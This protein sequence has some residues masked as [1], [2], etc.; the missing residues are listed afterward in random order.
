MIGAGRQARTQVEAVCAV[1]PIR[2]IRVYS[3][4]SEHAAAFADEL[5]LRYRIPVIASKQMHREAVKDAQIVVAATTSATPVVR[6][7][8][9]QP[10][11]HVNGIGSFRPE[12]QEV[13]IVPTAKIVVDQRASAWQEAGDLIIP[14]AQGLITEDSVHAEIGEIAAKL[15][16]GRTDPD[17]ITFFKSV[18]NAVQDAAVAE[19]LVIPLGR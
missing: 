12:M 1:R 19:R 15:R 11:T 6:L 14:R 9:L 5:R 8:D 10:G 18:G 13:E 16:P 17:E 2:Q 7:R 4:H 3:L